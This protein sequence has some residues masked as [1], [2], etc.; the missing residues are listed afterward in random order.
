MPAFLKLYVRLVDGLCRRVGLLAMALVFVMVGVLLLDAVMR[1]VVRM[2]L[3]WCVEF[4][5]FTLAAYY[6][7]GGAHSLA[8]N[9]HV[10]MDL[11]YGRLSARG[12]A[13]MDLTTVGCLL[14][15]LGVMLVGSISSLTYAIETDEKRFSMWNPSM[16]PIKALMVA[17]LVLML[18][19][20]LSLAVKHVATLR[21]VDLE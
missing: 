10:R 16:I 7:L 21:G 3:H 19:Q 20:G 2:P 14:F 18:L 1:N 15:Y 17:C 8:D 13:W 6:F 5:Q 12:K 9:S 11:I 4:A